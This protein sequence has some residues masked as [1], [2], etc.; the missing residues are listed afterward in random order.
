MVV[1]VSYMKP[2]K[3][4]IVSKNSNL[5]YE[6]EGCGKPIVIITET[7]IQKLRDDR[8]TK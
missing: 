6:C 5:I 4:K 1:K 7:S 8:M 3:V 2:K